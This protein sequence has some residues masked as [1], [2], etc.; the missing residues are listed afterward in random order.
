MMIFIQIIPIMII[1][2]FI[3]IIIILPAKSYVRFKSISYNLYISDNFPI[4]SDSATSFSVVKLSGAVAIFV[5][6]TLRD[7]TLNEPLL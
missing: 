3:M 7:K 1:I 4:L 6:D 5:Q 2:I